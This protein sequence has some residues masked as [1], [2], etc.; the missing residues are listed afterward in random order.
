MI[1]PRGVVLDELTC[2][3]LAPVVAEH[4]ELLRA[5]GAS[6][7]ARLLAAVVV[8][9][10]GVLGESAA[11]RREVAP[12][13][14]GASGGSA[15]LAGVGLTPPGAIGIAD[16]ASVLG[17]SAAHARRLVRRGVLTARRSGGVWLV[18]PTSVEV[19]RRARR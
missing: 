3:L 8:E 17:V 10:A 13:G 1:V 2:R 19:Y 18:D 14:G 12:G 5:R 6:A 11:A 15:T 7:H 4:V 16:T 9:M